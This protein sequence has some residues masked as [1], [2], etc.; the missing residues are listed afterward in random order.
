MSKASKCRY[1]HGQSTKICHS[2]TTLLDSPH[3]TFQV[4]EAAEV[5]FFDQSIAYGT[6]TLSRACATTYQLLI[7]LDV[8]AEGGEALSGTR[9]RTNF[10]QDLQLLG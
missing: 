1:T 7:F 2:L 6:S 10:G 4:S 3:Y 8:Q 9:T 5:F